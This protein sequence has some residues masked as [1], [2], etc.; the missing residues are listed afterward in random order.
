[1][2]RIGVCLLGTAALLLAGCR[3]AGRPH[4]VLPPSG[5]DAARICCPAC[6][7][8]LAALPRLDGAQPVEELIGIALRQNPEIQAA[9]LRVQSLAYQIPV[10]SS[11]EDPMLGLTA[12]PAPVQTATGQQDFI[13]SAS[14]K[15]PWHGKRLTKACIAT[16]QVDVARAELQAVELATI[17]KV[18]RAYYELYFAQQSIQVTENE[19]QLLGELRQ[20]ANARYKTGEVSQ[21]DVLRADLEISG[22]EDQLI[23]LRQQL[24][25]AQARLSRVLHVSPDS[26]LQ[27][28]DQ[29]PTEQAP[30]DLQQLQQQA[31]AAR[32]E[33]RAQLAA[34][35]RDRRAVDLAELDYKPD[36]TL[37]FSWIDVSR[38]GV[39]PVA[40]GQ[41]SFLLTTGLNLPVY[42]KRLDA[43]V[44][45]ARAKAVSTARNYD[46]L[47]DGT[48]EEVADLF[49]QASSQ[50]DLLILLREDIL[51]KARR[52]LAVSRQAYR[53]GET[54]FLQLID[55]WRQL[56]RY[57]V[58]LWRLEASQ[59]QTLAA[60]E[61]VVGD[62]VA[63]TVAPPDSA[64]AAEDLP[65]P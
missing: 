17:A 49:A 2:A 16:A 27:A 32:P 4:H 43:S 40:N 21:Q 3:S 6:P 19:Q 44:R 10:V 11:L 35:C 28:L 5:I 24:I 42:R 54:D 63:E 39:S 56:L 57:E 65:S 45:S 14:Q 18:K 64:A 12:Q 13:L 53:V 55:N 29:L 46:A 52:T 51:P 48:L 23:R 7:A 31:I 58:N 33:L 50:R 34:V 36:F 9:R 61:R 59:R 37:G 8:P 22:V 30:L 60:L 38:A 26:Q 20:V 41:D 15:V 62:V 25:S 47:R 1:M